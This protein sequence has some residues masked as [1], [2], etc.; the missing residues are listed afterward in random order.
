MSSQY[1]NQNK[2]QYQIDSR[3]NNLRTDGNINSQA[4]NANGNIDSDLVISAKSYAQ[5]GFTGPFTQITSLS[6]SIDA[7]SIGLSRLFQVK[8]VNA[9]LTLGG[10]DKFAIQLPA[11][12]VTVRSQV[13][14]TI[15]DYSGS[16]S[17]NGTPL[18]YVGNINPSINN[19]EIIVKNMG[20]GQSLNGVLTLNITIID[21]RD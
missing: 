2:P 8:T 13:I 20:L 18:C 7:T 17:T 19:I 6:T 11:G 15:Y 5:D 3:F 4:I 1:I 16:Y 10:V 14:C 12:V 9:T 21:G